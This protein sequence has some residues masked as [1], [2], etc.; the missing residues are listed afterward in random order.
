MR[1]AKDFF[2]KFKNLT[3]PG[4]A[5]RTALT[6]AIQGVVGVKVPKDGIKVANGIAYIN[7]S[8]IAKQEIK[9]H[10]GEVLRELYERLP[11][12]REAV[13]DIR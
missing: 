12:A 10:R 1:L 13:R 5:L 2:S 4:G 11:K 7:V 6:Q 3:P 9:V 8:S